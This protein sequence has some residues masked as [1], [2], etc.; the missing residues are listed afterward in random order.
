M[1]VDNETTKRFIQESGNEKS[2]VVEISEA[3]HMT[4]NNDYEFAI[5]MT[6]E[7]I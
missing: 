6:Q 3:D 1:V 5:Q 7:I 2:R 4:I